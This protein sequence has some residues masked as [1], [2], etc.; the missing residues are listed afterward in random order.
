MT[1]TAPIKAPGKCKVGK[2]EAGLSGHQADSSS[3]R[4]SE[5]R[6]PVRPQMRPVPSPSLSFD[7]PTS[8]RTTRPPGKRPSRSAPE[9]AVVSVAANDP[10]ESSF[11]A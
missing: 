5:V 9:Q 7:V 2:G 1:P 11:A 6:I 10:D 4:P 8:S 3:P